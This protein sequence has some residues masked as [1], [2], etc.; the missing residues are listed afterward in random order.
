MHQFAAA[1]LDLGF[2]PSNVAVIMP[3]VVVRHWGHVVKVQCSVL[4]SCAD[5]IYQC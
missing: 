3:P 5:I 1:T 4:G 2:L